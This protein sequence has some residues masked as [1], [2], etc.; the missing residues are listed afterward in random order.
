NRDTLSDSVV[1]MFKNSR[2]DLIRL[3][4]HGNP[5]DESIDSNKG[6][7]LMVNMN[8]YIYWEIVKFY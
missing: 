8:V 3:L 1:D 5:S 2:D 4:F 6:V 7:R